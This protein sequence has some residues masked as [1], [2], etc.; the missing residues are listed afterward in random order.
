MRPF[1]GKKKCRKVGGETFIQCIFMNVSHC[2]K[3]AHTYSINHIFPRISSILLFQNIL[4]SSVLFIY[5]LGSF[6]AI[7]TFQDRKKTLEVILL[8]KYMNIILIKL[9]WRIR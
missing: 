1:F 6:V 8:H 9:V 5:S 7:I 3:K 4:R 2:S